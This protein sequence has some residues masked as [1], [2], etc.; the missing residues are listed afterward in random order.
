[1]RLR[2]SLFTKILCW[3][4]LNL[5]LLAV[6][7]VLIFNLQ[8]NVNPLS[9]LFGQSSKRIEAVGQLISEESR[10]KTREERDAIVQRYTEAY[11]VT[12]FLFANDGRQLGGKEVTLPADVMVILRK[13]RPRDEPPPPDMLPP[14]DQPPPPLRHP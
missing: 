6:A 13:D 2:F 10:N 4:F 5:L 1:M 9:P 8:F 3:F 12:F 7:L 14:A 11:G